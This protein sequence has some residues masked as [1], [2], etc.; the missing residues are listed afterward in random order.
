M[1]KS[2]FIIFTNIRIA[3]LQQCK[4]QKH[5]IFKLNVS[6]YLRKKYI[7]RC[8]KIH[9]RMYSSEKANEIIKKI[10]LFSY[11]NVIFPALYNVSVFSFITGV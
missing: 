2:L 1:L 11:D 6:S 4:F 5:E 10:T 8:F 7:G 3:M 9:F